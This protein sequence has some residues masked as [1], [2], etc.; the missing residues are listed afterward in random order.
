MTLKSVAFDGSSPAGSF[1]IPATFNLGH[2]WNFRPERSG[3]FSSLR[4]ISA[5]LSYIVLL[6]R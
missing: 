5:S 1:K 4:M 3:M 2:L 6:E